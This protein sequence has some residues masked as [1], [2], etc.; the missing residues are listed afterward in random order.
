DALLIA[1]ASRDPTMPAGRVWVRARHIVLSSA[2]AILFALLLAEIESPNS[3]SWG[4][5]LTLVVGSVATGL[6]LMVE[7]RRPA[8]QRSPGQ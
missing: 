8:E 4:F 1:S 5:F 7:L 3:Y 2:T 6:A